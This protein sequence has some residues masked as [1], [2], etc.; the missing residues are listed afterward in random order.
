MLIGLESPIPTFP[1]REGQQRTK[2]TYL[3]ILFKYF[4][5]DYRTDVE[6]LNYIN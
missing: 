6:M 2:P 1:D 3:A 5:V 4:F